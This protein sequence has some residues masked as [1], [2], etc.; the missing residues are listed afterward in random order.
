MPSLHYAMESLRLEINLM[1]YIMIE[2]FGHDSAPGDFRIRVFARESASRQPYRLGKSS[3]ASNA[4][5]RVRQRFAGEDGSQAG[6]P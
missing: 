1:D 5:S 3:V 2:R 6:R 4:T